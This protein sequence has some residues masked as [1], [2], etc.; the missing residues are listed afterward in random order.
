[1]YLGE[2]IIRKVGKTAEVAAGTS[3]TPTKGKK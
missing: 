1:M 2:Q 3:A